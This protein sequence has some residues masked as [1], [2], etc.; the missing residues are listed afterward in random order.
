M[1]SKNTFIGYVRVSSDYQK[2]NTSLP[3]QREEIERYCQRKGYRL[4][5]IFEDVF[6]AESAQE[7]EGFQRALA[8]IFANLAD[9]MICYKLDRFA[10][11]VL[12]AESVKKELQ[13]RGKK[14]ITVVDTLDLDTP[15][16]ELM[17][18][19]KGMFAEYERKQINLRT[20]QGRER[21]RQ[22]GGY[23]GGA[24]PYGWRPYK[25]G[26]EE[27]P[28]EQAVIRRV[29]QMH[30]DG[31]SFPH[32]ARVLNA[33]GVRTKKRT[34]WSAGSFYRWF[35]GRRQS[36]IRLGLEITEDARHG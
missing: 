17:F 9:G 27:V 1:A 8:C 26:L 23:L 5:G 33:E 11:R 31:M 32:I 7:R 2:D 21:K 29:K 13:D 34:K 35:D 4:F 3:I 28:E 14:L 6:S 10:R 24:P 15:D 25:G 22:E 16:G 19:F 12:D 18:T 36:L 30:Q 20:S